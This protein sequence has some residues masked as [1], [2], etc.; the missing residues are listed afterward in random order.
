M[1]TA[2]LDA[3]GSDLLRAGILFILLGVVL[4]LM[5]RRYGKQ[6]EQRSARLEREYAV[7]TQE[8]LNAL[9]DEEL[10]EAVIANLNAKQ[11]KQCPDP[12][13]VLPQLSRGRT[14]VYG[15]WLVQKEL[16]HGDFETLLA[17]PSARFCEFAIE[18]LRQF[19]AT[20]CA[21]AIT[22]AMQ[23]EEGV[24]SARCHAA[25]LD[26]AKEERPLVACVEYIRAN[27]EEFTDEEGA[28][29]NGDDGVSGSV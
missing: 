16:E 18:G 21:D 24:T 5:N 2:S 7:L 29:E 13:A 12:Y 26:A 22:Q 17:G 15:V 11:D 1:V 20:A 6:E 14:L 23:A 4:W 28:R 8:K 10:V 9:S 27:A 19:G 25:Y 3:W